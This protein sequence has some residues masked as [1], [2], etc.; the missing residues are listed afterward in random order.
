MEP[1]SDHSSLR[2]HVSVCIFVCMVILSPHVTYS[3]NLSLSKDNNFYAVSNLYTGFDIYLTK[4]GEPTGIS[5]RAEVGDP[6]PTPVLFVHGDQALLT[7]SSIGV[8][9][10]WATASGRPHQSLSVTS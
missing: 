7:G 3:A 6:Y 5:M 10:L 1:Y 2:L 8:P 4:S 9:R